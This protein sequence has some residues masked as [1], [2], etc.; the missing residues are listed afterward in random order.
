MSPTRSEL[1]LRVFLCSTNC[2]YPK[3]MEK[4]TRMPTVKGRIYVK[5]VF[6][7]NAKAGRL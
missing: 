6:A 3:L 5:P 7:F 4:G 1:L 2:N